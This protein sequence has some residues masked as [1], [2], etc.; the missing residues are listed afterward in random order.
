MVEIH[1]LVIHPGRCEVPVVDKPVNLTTEFGI[2][3]YL[4]QRPVWVFI[5]SQIVDEVKGS[6]YFVTDRSV[7]VQI[8]ELRRKLGPA[9]VYIK[10]S[11]GVG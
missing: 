9:G 8:V 4:A 10:T 2:L 1:N 6:E 7:D 3:S 5:R 11:R